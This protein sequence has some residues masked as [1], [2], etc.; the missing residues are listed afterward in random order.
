MMSLVTSGR[1][2]NI[3]RIAKT[4]FINFKVNKIDGTIIRV[5]MISG[6]TTKTDAS[7]MVNHLVK[8]VRDKKE[9]E[10]IYS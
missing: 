5:T 8:L 3:G 6:A 4:P 9:E 10:A 2:T 7:S 1:G